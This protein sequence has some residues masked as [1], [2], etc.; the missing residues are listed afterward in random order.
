MWKLGSW[1]VPLFDRYFYC[2]H[3]QQGSVFF[4]ENTHGQMAEAI[5]RDWWRRGIMMADEMMEV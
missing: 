1:Y 3:V 2:V 5:L 4:Q